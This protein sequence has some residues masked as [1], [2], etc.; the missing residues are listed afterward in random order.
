MKNMKHVLMLVALTGTHE[1]IAMN[2]LKAKQEDVKAAPRVKS[3]A[4]F[5]AVRKGDIPGITNALLHLDMSLST[6]DSF[7]NTPLHIAALSWRVKTVELLRELAP[8][9]KVDWNQ[10]VNLKNQEGQTALDVA[11]INGHTEIVNFLE[12]LNKK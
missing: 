11:K 2:A 7:G 4:L 1:M 8:I 3:K 10:Y 12:Q 9:K 5:D 6:R